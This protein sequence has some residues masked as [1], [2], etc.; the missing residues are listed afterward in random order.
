MKS[1]EL[2]DNRKMTHFLSAP[3]WMIIGAFATTCL[4][5]SISFSLLYLDR[6]I[7]STI[8]PTAILEIIPA[9]SLLVTPTINSESLSP[10]LATIPPTQEA[11][12]IE[13]GG[14]VQII[15]TG[16]DGLRLRD[17]P[18]L[19]GNILL[20]A[21]EAEVFKLEDGPIDMDGYTWWH[22]VGPFDTS[23]QGWA[24][25]NYLEQIQNP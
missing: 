1:P 23:R 21:S 16:G 12:V 9:S 7:A 15:G 2:R 3:V 22:L 19:N 11:G 4:L 5:I 8:R 20:I 17:Q 10:D 6:S 14:Y 24:V 13:I 18:G 25:E